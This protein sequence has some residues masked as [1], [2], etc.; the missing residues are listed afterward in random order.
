MTDSNHVH[1]HYREMLRIRPLH[2]TTDPAHYSQAVELGMDPGAKWSLEATKGV[3][4]AGGNEGD[5]RPSYHPDD[6]EVGPDPD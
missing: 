2:S 3:Y 4:E 1:P 5:W 6:A